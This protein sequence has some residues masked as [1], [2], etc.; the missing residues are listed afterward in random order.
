M[1]QLESE[2]ADICSQTSNLRE[3][4]CLLPVNVRVDQLDSALLEDLPSLAIH[5]LHG[6]LLL[7][8]ILVPLLEGHVDRVH[9]RVV[10]HFLNNIK[11]LLGVVWG[12]VNHWQTVI[13]QAVDPVQGVMV[14]GF[15]EVFVSSCLK[16]SCYQRC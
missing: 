1:Q 16:E 12:P 13:F 9:G 3:V 7:Q 10:Y 8:Q 11:E 15:L 5:H 4:K 2:G 14:E 6:D